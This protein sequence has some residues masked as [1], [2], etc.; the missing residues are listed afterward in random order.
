MTRIF[1]LSDDLLDSGN[2]DWEHLTTM[3]DAMAVVGQDGRQVVVSA[4][5]ART[6]NFVWK[7]EKMVGTVA[8]FDLVFNRLA[9]PRLSVAPW[10]LHDRSS[11]RDPHRHD[12]TGTAVVR[13]L[14]VAFSYFDRFHSISSGSFTGRFFLKDG[15]HYA[16]GAPKANLYLGQVYLCPNCFDDDDVDDR[17]EARSSIFEAPVVFDAASLTLRGQQF[18]E[19]FGQALCSVDLNGDGFDDLVIGAPLHAQS[20]GVCDFANKWAGQKILIKIL[21]KFLSKF[22]KI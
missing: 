6:Q 7:Q 4:P 16:V 1:D 14:L 12:L 8:K 9:L 17:L 10:G 19:R 5:L 22:P 13:G 15:D 20:K 3:G 21:K 2:G 11:D 18:G